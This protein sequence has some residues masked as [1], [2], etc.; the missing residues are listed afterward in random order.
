LLR[1]GKAVHQIGQAAIDI[2]LVV[3]K[4]EAFM[5]PAGVKAR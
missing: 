2:E 1:G 4:H 3:V 5:A